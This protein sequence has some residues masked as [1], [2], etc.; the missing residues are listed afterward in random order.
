MQSILRPATRRIQE[1]RGRQSP[2]AV[3]KKCSALCRMRHRRRTCATTRAVTSSRF[4]SCS[5]TRA[6]RQPSDTWAASS[7]SKMASMIG[8]VWSPMRA[9]SGDAGRLGANPARSFRD[10]ASSPSAPPTHQE[11]HHYQCIP[12]RSDPHRYEPMGPL[13][14]LSDKDSAPRH[15]LAVV[16]QSTR[17]EGLIGRWRARSPGARLRHQ[18]PLRQVLWSPLVGPCI[19]A[20]FP[21][22]V[23]SPTALRHALSP[24][25][26]PATRPA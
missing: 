11:A 4:D 26:R 8:L 18:T 12:I 13:L 6:S 24:T 23:H 17:T 16:H 25:T 1:R 10:R 3:G 21:R 9:Y 7:G 19:P 15:L 14:R 2:P 20:Y 5:A 22:P